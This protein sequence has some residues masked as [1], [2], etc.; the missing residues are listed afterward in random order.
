MTK[1]EFMNIYKEQE[2]VFS[3][4]NKYGFIFKNDILSIGIGGDYDEI[5]NFIVTTEPVKI[6]DLSL[7]IR[8]VKIKSN[9]YSTA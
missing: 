3:Y 6:K 1:K 8:W 7:P 9:F 4:Y 2:V 5:Y